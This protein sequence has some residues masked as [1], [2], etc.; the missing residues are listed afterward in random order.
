MVDFAELSN[1]LGG[2]AL[3]L[4]KELDASTLNLIR[5][6]ETLEKLL[7]AVGDLEDL[8]SHFVEVFIINVPPYESVFMESRM[9]GSSAFEVWGHYKEMGYAPRMEGVV[10]PDHVALELAFFSIL[11]AEHMKSGCCEDALLEFAEAHLM[12]WLPLLRATLEV[13]FPTSPYTAA[14]RIAEELVEEVY[15]S[16]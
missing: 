13:N 4:Y 5:Q 7:A 1:A 11:L 3:F 8:K 2:L 6:V 9:W 15:R 10:G 16:L 12:R 14:V